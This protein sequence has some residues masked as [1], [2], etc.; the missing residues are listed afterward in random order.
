M[1]RRRIYRR[2]ILQE[3]DQQ[4]VWHGFFIAIL[5]N[6]FSMHIDLVPLN[7]KGTPCDLEYSLTF[8]SRSAAVQCFRRAVSRLLNPCNAVVAAG[9]ELTF[10]KIQWQALIKGFLSEEISI[11]YGT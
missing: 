4:G 10:S 8:P 1:G 2:Q 5:T 6:L 3:R 7:S 9:A 11:L